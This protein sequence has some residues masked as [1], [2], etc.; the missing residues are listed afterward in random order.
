MDGGEPPLPAF[1][2]SSADTRPEIGVDRF[3]Y[4]VHAYVGD[5]L[6]GEL[7]GPGAWSFCGDGEVIADAGTRPDCSPAD[8][9]WSIVQSCEAWDVCEWGGVEPCYHC[10]AWADD[11]R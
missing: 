11:P 4:S 9:G 2:C 10:P 3:C 1:T 8:H 7:D 6:S 5:V